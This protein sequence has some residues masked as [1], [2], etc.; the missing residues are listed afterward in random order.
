MMV[1]M[2]LSTMMVVLIN[3][4][5]QDSDWVIDLGAS[6]HVTSHGEFF[7]A[8]T[9]GNFGNAKMVTVVHPRLLWVLV[10]STWKPTLAAS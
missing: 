6:Y 9:C 2:L 8:Y 3:L 10:I 4:V 5:C 1:I 7:T